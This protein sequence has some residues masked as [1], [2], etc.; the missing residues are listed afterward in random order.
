MLIK[1]DWIAAVVSALVLSCAAITQASARQT[2]EVA[3][4]LDT[5][6]SMGPLIEGAKRKIWAIATSI[7]D[8]NPN[9]DIR[10]GLVAYRDIGDDYVTKRF[11]L[12]TDIQDLHGKA[13]NEAVT[14]AGDLVADYAAGR[15]KLD[16]IKDDELPPALRNLPKPERSAALEQQSNERKELNAK[17]AELVATRDAYIAE[18]QTKQ[19]PRTSTFDQAVAA[20]LKAQIK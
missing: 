13:S 9:A 18:Q 1:R 17:L 12:T 14:G 10:M 2:V 8:A 20:T 6:G 15:A 5:T 11:D 19:Q 7:F 4:V 16:Q 3:F